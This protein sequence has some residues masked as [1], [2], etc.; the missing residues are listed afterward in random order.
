MIDQYL[1]E[2]NIKREFAHLLN[3]ENK[4]VD[5]KFVVENK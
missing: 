3:E 1:E 4:K 2:S 5:S